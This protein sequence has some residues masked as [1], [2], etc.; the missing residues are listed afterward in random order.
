MQPVGK[1]AGTYARARQTPVRKVVKTVRKRPA[2]ARAS[3]T[4]ML[5]HQDVL[6]QE[7]VCTVADLQMITNIA[8]F[9]KRAVQLGVPIR[10]LKVDGSGWAMRPKAEIIKEYMFKLVVFARTQ[11]EQLQAI[12]CISRFR[13]KAVGLGLVV[14]VPNASRGGFMYRR[15]SEILEDYIR[16][17]MKLYDLPHIGEE[18][19]QH[20]L[21]KFG[22]CFRT[23]SANGVVSSMSEKDLFQRAAGGG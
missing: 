9:R 6:R 2:A 5:A 4:G 13:A 8:D 17:L 18:S 19:A 22:I 21:A 16:K 14:S 7:D 23:D 10:V 12:T 1:W 20:D 3:K 11:V 15:K